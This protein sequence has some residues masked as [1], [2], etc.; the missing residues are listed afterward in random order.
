MPNPRTPS[1]AFHILHIANY[2]GVTNFDRK[3]VEVRRTISFINTHKKNPNP[4]LPLCS[5]TVSKLNNTWMI[6]EI[7]K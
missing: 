5:C 6:K 3:G 4:Y 2:Q 1:W 7:S